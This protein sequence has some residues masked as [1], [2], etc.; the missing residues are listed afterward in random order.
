MRL[1]LHAVVY[2]TVTIMGYVKGHKDGY[3]DCKMSIYKEI[4]D[5]HKRLKEINKDDN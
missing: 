1:I 4:E 2:I 3:Y 5:I